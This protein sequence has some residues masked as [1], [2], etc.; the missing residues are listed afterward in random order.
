MSQYL[1]NTLVIVIIA[2]IGLICKV[3][4]PYIKALIST[5]DLTVYERWAEIIVKAAEMIWTETNSGVSK[6]EYAVDM[7]NRIFNSKKEVLSEEQID[8]LIEACVKATNENR[9]KYS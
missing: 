4:I 7:M 3:T 6:K 2:V 5:Q 8:T 9:R 1:F